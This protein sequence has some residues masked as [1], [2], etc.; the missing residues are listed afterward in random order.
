MRVRSREFPI[1]ICVL[2]LLLFGAGCRRPKPALN[3][4]C[5][6]L[7][8]DSGSQAWEVRPRLGATIDSVL[9]AQ[10]RGRMVLRAFARSDS[11]P[12]A[13]TLTAS[14]TGGPNLDVT[15][16]EGPDGAATIEPRASFYVVATRCF[17]CPRTA[18]PHT[19][20]PG[21]VD[22]LDLY[23]GQAQVQCKAAT[24]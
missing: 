1:A 8:V 24:T 23:L 16:H 10:G 3:L 5:D 11:T 2:A 13:D 14:L 15:F 19:V 7:V 18:W 21:R 20:A 4:T 6:R 22:T 17:R 12:I 9:Y